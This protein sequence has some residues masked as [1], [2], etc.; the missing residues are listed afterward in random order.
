MYAK[1]DPYWLATRY[2]GA[3]HGCGATI[4]KGSRAFYWPKG[5]RLECTLCGETSE[6]RFLAE[7]ADETF[8]NSGAY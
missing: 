3:C 2:P 4:A 1:G 8:Y 7:I 5:K 6:R